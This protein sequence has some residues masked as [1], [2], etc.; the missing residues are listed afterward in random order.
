MK[1][2]TSHI[3]SCLKSAIISPWS[4][5]S[6]TWRVTMW[7]ATAI[8]EDNVRAN[9]QV[10]GLW[11]AS[12]H[13][14]FVVNVLNPHTPSNKK[15]S[16]PTCFDNHEQVKWWLYEQHIYEVELTSF[17]LLACV[18]HYW[19][20]WQV[21]S[22]LHQASCQHDLCKQLQLDTLEGETMAQ[23]KICTA[24]IPGNMAIPVE[25]HR[26]QCAIH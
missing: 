15:F 16:I 23:Y 3:A 5:F 11:G 1:T 18:Q 20:N 12:H 24:S 7:Y 9:I 10:N 8:T 13:C 21:S 6:S 26:A 22:C 14:I 2:E 17:T 19:G 4:Q 25:W